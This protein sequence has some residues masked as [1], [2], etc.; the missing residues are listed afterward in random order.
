MTW[1]SRSIIVQ[2]DFG[3]FPTV[4]NRD[5]LVVD[6]GTAFRS[7]HGNLSN[8]RSGSAGLNGLHFGV[9]FALLRGGS[10]GP[11]S[12]RS[13]SASVGKKDRFSCGGVSCPI[14]ECIL[15]RTD[16]NG[17]PG[18]IIDRR[19]DYPIRGGSRATMLTT[20]DDLFR[21]SEAAGPQTADSP[22]PI[23]RE[24]IFGIP[25][26]PEVLF[27]D[28][29]NVY[30]T[31]IEKRQRQLIVK[32]GFIRSFLHPGERVILITTAYSPLRLAEQL[33]TAG[34]FLEL[35]RALL[36]WTSYRLLHV[37]VGRHKRYRHA[38]AQIRYGDIQAIRLRR[39]A[40]EIDYK[41]G[42]TEIFKAVDFAERPKIR[43]LLPALPLTQKVLTPSARTHLCPRCARSLIKPVPSCKNCGLVFKTKA[44]MRA[45][46]LLSPG[47]AYLYLRH[48]RP[49]VYF[50]LAE[51]AAVST[52]A[53]FFLHQGAMALG[54]G[55]IWMALA[56][57][58]L[59][60]GLAWVHSTHLL[61]EFVPC[62]AGPR[63]VVK[64]PPKFSW[65]R[66]GPRKTR[67]AA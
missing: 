14:T 11:P 35:E 4:A 67:V 48:R 49:F 30:R 50:T 31:R 38:I 10:A 2:D 66:F 13:E 12:R 19:W 22:A 51:S 53:L 28:A 63:A 59:L 1:P 23:I 7:L 25:V 64:N 20:T 65:L 6:E 44:R 45:A 42:A 15:L 32:L 26:D 21:P 61:D 36:V 34:L 62:R 60:R 57:L 37:P 5:D 52:G 41:K 46:T 24:R 29:H 39:G 55:P 40:L 16:S 8:C 56:A 43:Q 58:M 18:T 17:P 54:S 9:I 47:G 33:L 3:D 27:A